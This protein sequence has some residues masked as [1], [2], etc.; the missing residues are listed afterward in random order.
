MRYMLM[1]KFLDKRYV[2]V[3]RELYKNSKTPYNELSKRVGVSTTTCY[4]LVKE[5]E[6][7]GIIKAYTIEIDAKKL[8][9]PIKTLIEVKTRTGVTTE[10]VRVLGTYP[11]VSRIYGITGDRD[12]IIEAYFRSI[13]E[14]DLFLKRIREI[15][16]DIKDTETHIVLNEHRNPKGWF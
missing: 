15:C 8:G 10:L 2:N 12:A 3:L 16:L 13:E 9:F 1:E 11:N 6:K 14:L 4:R 5:L 7:L